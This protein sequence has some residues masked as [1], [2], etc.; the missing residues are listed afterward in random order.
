MD[1]CPFLTAWLTA[2]LM[3]TASGWAAEW[4]VDASAAADGNGSAERPFRKIAEGL[5]AMQGGDIVTVRQ[6]VYHETLSLSKGGSR[7]RPSTLRA[8][9]GHRVIISGFT[10]VHG[11]TEAGPGVYTTTVDGQVKDLYV[12]YVP[13]RIASSLDQQDA[14]ADVIAADLQTGRLTVGDGD[15]SLPSAAQLVDHLAGACIFMFFQ[16]GNFFRTVPVQATRARTAESCATWR[17]DSASGAWKRHSSR[18]PSVA[19]MLSCHSIR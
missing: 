17:T 8:A 10:P 4:Y 15:A 13:Q 9:P 7:G 3:T 14:W 1:A 5:K 6:G 12:G 19:S 18:A 16:R 11:W 2:L